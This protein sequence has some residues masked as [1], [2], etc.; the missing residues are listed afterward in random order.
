MVFE[1]VSLLFFPF[2]SGR[3]TSSL[4]ALPTSPPSTRTARAGV[5]HVFCEVP[6]KRANNLFIRT[7]VLGVMVV[8]AWDPDL[9]RAGCVRMERGHGRP[10]GR[11]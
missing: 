10:G 11:A 7:P 9:V 6:E 3:S 8:A 4:S 2:P 5:L 1:V